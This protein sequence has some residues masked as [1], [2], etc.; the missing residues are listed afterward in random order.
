MEWYSLLIL[1]HTKNDAMTIPELI[2]TPYICVGT[3]LTVDD[4]MHSGIT[5]SWHY[6]LI[7]RILIEPSGK[8]DLYL[9]LLLEAKGV[10]VDVIGFKQREQ[11][12]PTIDL[13]SAPQ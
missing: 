5:M 10:K 11:L 3:M 4:P 9:A 6:E 2:K 12:D 8:L 13:K 7:D 1:S